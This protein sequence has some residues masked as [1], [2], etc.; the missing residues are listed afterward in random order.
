MKFQI[1][2]ELE[3]KDFEIDIHA[4]KGHTK[5]ITCIEIDS[6]NQFV[7]SASKDGSMIKCKKNLLFDFRGSEYW[8]ESHFESG[9]FR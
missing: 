9:S 7:Y 8:T 3:S 5:C 4:Y 1:H 6:S 2:K